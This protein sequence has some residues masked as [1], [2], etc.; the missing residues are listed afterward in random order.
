[1]RFTFPSKFNNLGIVVLCWMWSCS[2]SMLTLLLRVK[3]CR[4]SS[5]ILHSLDH[6]PC[7]MYVQRSIVYYIYEQ[8]NLLIVEASVHWKFWFCYSFSNKL[9]FQKMELLP[10]DCFAHI[11]SFTSPQDVCRSS[12][13][14]S[15]VQ[16]MADSDAVWEKFL[17]P[18]YHQIVSRFLSS[19][20]SCSSKKQLFSMLCNPQLIDDG[21]KVIF[22]HVSPFVSMH[23]CN[24]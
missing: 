2:A 4:H 14:S 12:M 21:N 7:T 24:L 8:H 17:P 11:L 1:M 16:S 13:V 22:F 5:D 9:C 3:K 6:V 20:L 19:S 10:Y 18:N 23:G 15:I